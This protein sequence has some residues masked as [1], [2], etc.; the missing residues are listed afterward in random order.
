MKKSLKIIALGIVAMLFAG[1][2]TP[3]NAG[4]KLKY[5]STSTYEV[6]S[7][8]RGPEGTNV[9]RLYPDVITSAPSHEAVSSW[10]WRCRKGKI[11]DT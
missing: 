2:T 6:E 8:A 10:E 3:A 11:P 5:T 1:A 4:G 9:V 7:L